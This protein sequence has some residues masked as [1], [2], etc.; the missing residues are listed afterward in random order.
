M[1]NAEIFVIARHWC[2]WTKRE[3]AYEGLLREKELQGLKAASRSRIGIGIHI[4]NMFDSIESVRALRMPITI[5]RCSN[6][7]TALLLG[8][9]PI[10]HHYD[11]RVTI[12]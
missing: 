9:E 5:R 6:P 11:V 4:I 10:A 3:N 7:G 1:L 2:G 8:I 12:V